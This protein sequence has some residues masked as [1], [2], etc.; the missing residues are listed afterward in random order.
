M[1]YSL[2]LLCNDIE[3]YQLFQ[4]ALLEVYRYYNYHESLLS[5]TKGI[6][7]YDIANN[8]VKSLLSVYKI[9]KNNNE[10]VFNN[11]LEDIQVIRDNSLK[12]VEDLLIFLNKNDCIKF[13][14]NNKLSLIGKLKTYTNSIEN[15]F[16]T[17]K[18]PDITN[19]NKKIDFEY[20]FSLIDFHMELYDE[21]LTLC[22]YIICDEILNVKPVNN[23]DV[24][25]SEFHMF[26]SHFL[27]AYVIDRKFVGTEEDSA[28]MFVCN[29]LSRSIK[30]LERGS[31]DMVKI[32]VATMIVNINDNNKKHLLS[33][34]IKLRQNEYFS[35]SKDV[36]ERIKLYIQWLY[37]IEKLKERP[38]I[39][40]QLE[41]I[42]SLLA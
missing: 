7:D 34:L 38:E 14:T 32:L 16:D 13:D 36:N 35:I 41:V 42:I 3:K 31:L 40:N 21:L 37:N 2:G 12:V 26:L 18:I 6:R 17:P 23:K 27:F 33:D 15:F 30:H 4:H 39:K 24:Y 25:I 9:N 29:N 8:I 5:I 20:N 22:E 11:E 1:K 28:K 10:I 19:Y